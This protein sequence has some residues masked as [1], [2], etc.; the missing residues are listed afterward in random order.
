MSTRSIRDDEQSVV[1]AVRHLVIDGGRSKTRARARQADGSV[2]EVIGPGMPIVTQPGAADA[3]RERV[4]WISRELG[5]RDVETL[6]FASNGVHIP[7]PVVETTLLGLI[8]QIIAADR[9]VIAS[10]MVTSFVGALGIRPGI[11]LATGTGTIAMAVDDSLEAR[12]IDGWGPY[13]GDRGSGYALGR[14]ALDVVHR[15]AD[16]ADDAPALTRAWT[17]LHGSLQEGATTIYSS[18]NPVGVV[19]AFAEQVLALAARG[20]EVATSLVDTQVSALVDTVRLCRHHAGPRA[21]LAMTGGLSNS[22]YLRERLRSR[23]PPDQTWRPA[24]GDAVD[25][26]ELLA[27]SKLPVLTSVSAW[28]GRHSQKPTSS[29]QDPNPAPTRDVSTSAMP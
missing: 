22:A 29:R 8:R 18:D 25:G 26:A 21:P 12:R 19:A 24:Q 16:G 23:L 2:R 20:D 5:A 10:D 11:V 3:V 27:R 15:T 14:A 17:D 6:V 28:Y 13:A 1:S 4:A 7:D 9:V